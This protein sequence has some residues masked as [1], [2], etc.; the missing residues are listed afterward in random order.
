MEGGRGGVRV[1]QKERIE[2]GKKRQARGVWIKK[3]NEK[4]K[5]RQDRQKCA[6]NV[7]VE[8][9]LAT[10]RWLRPP[11]PPN[12]MCVRVLHSRS[13]L[14]I[15]F[16][17]H[18]RCSGFIS[19]LQKNKYSKEGKDDGTRMKRVVRMEEMSK[20]RKK[21]V[22]GGARK[23]FNVGRSLPLPLRALYPADR[24]WKAPIIKRCLASTSTP[25]SPPPTHK[26][27]IIYNTHNS[28]KCINVISEDKLSVDCQLD[29]T[30]GQSCKEPWAMN[31]ASGVGIISIQPVLSISGHVR[32]MTEHGFVASHRNVAID[33]FRWL[34]SGSSTVK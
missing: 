6:A 16:Y 9:S 2:D 3:R 34:L 7:Q 24:P 8:V 29:S 19:V 12:C 33:G 32:G 23:F 5:N 28:N 13:T 11:D 10:R 21:W 18:S 31:Y 1:S 14:P 30:G 26:R 22:S 20:E 17:F 4:N 15:S 25:Y 27:L